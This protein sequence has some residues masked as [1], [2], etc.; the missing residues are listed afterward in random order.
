[1]VAIALHLFLARPFH[2]RYLERIIWLSELAEFAAILAPYQLATILLM[3][4]LYCHSLR[5]VIYQIYG[6]RGVA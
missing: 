5:G 2:S 3:V 6:M 4:S 1:M